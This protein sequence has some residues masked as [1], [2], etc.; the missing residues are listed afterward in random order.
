MDQD[1]LRTLADRYLSE[2]LAD[3]REQ[4]AREMIAEI[5]GD[6]TIAVKLGD[7]NPSNVCAKGK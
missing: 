2:A 4:I 3:Y 5:K 6:A 7:P 1:K